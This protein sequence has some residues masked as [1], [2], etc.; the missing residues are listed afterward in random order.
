MSWKRLRIGAF[1]IPRGRR[2]AGRLLGPG[3]RGRGRRGPAPDGLRRARHRPRPAHRRRCRLP[4]RSRRGSGL[5]PLRPPP[6]DEALPVLRALPELRRVKGPTEAGGPI[7]PCAARAPVG[8][9]RVRTGSGIPSRSDCDCRPRPDRSYRRGL[10]GARVRSPSARRGSAPMVT[11]GRRSMT[12]RDRSRH[13]ATRRDRTV[14]GAGRVARQV[15]ANDQAGG[16]IMPDATTEP[17][18]Q[19]GRRAANSTTEPACQNGSGHSGWRRR[20]ASVRRGSF[21]QRTAQRA[22]TDRSHCRRDRIGQRVP[23]SS[24]AS[25]TQGSGPAHRTGF[26]PVRPAGRSGRVGRRRRRNRGAR[27]ATDRTQHWRAH[28]AEFSLNAGV[29]ASVPAS[30]AAHRAAIDPVRRRTG[31]SDRRSAQA[32]GAVGG[33]MVATGQRKPGRRAPPSRSSPTPRTRIAPGPS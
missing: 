8:R 23:R 16:A 17:A 28:I 10:A 7:A 4:R 14:R 30:R 27:R 18:C 33:K 15:R 22:A 11:H 25:T 6:P 26:G 24:V 12:P 32:G 2:P 21:G 5:P 1:A 9:A 19:N 13:G 29:A 3:R 20:D 31:D